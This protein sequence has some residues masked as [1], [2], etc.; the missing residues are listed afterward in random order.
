ML[1]DSNP[2]CWLVSTRISIYQYILRL[3]P[4]QHFSSHPGRCRKHTKTYCLC[5]PE[6]LSQSL[7][8][9]TPKHLNI[10]AL[11]ARTLVHNGKWEQQKRCML[12]DIAMKHLFEVFKHLWFPCH[13]KANNTSYNC[14]G[15]QWYLSRDAGLTRPS[16]PKKGEKSSVQSSSLLECTAVRHFLPML[17]DVVLVVVP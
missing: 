13:R 7:S 4:Y 2:S 17:F 6:H 16:A 10:S 9:L 3:D 5:N 1:R 11:N 15:K 12:S 8:C 14:G